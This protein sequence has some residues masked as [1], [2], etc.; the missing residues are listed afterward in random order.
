MYINRYSN[1][2]I[3]IYRTHEHSYSY[4]YKQMWFVS[5]SRRETIL[6]V[7]SNS[8]AWATKLLFLVRMWYL[9][10]TLTFYSDW[11]LNRSSSDNQITLINNSCPFLTMSRDSGTAVKPFQHMQCK[12][13]CLYVIF[14]IAF[15]YTCIWE[16]F[17]GNS[18]WEHMLKGN[19]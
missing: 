10:V 8:E 9:Q 5:V 11:R 18:L 12:M 2:G 17:H 14:S 6:S 13:C 7:I 16:S 3:N 4:R 19:I 1:N 15:S